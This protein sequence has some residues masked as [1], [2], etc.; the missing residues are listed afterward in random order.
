MKIITTTALALLILI[1]TAP[2]LMARDDSSENKSWLSSFFNPNDA[3]VFRDLVHKKKTLGV[4]YDVIEDSLRRSEQNLKEIGSIL[5]LKDDLLR[6]NSAKTR[7]STRISNYDEK[8]K[9]IQDSINDFKKK[10]QTTNT[11]QEVDKINNFIESLESELFYLS[12]DYE[13]DNERVNSINNDIVHINS[14]IQ[15]SKEES[16]K[17]AQLRNDL[18]TKEVEISNTDNRLSELLNRDSL[19][20]SFRLNISIAFTLLVGVVIVGFYR[21]A[22]TKDELAKT[23]FSGE[24]GIQFITLF[25]I[26]ISIILFGIMGSLQSEELSALLGALSGYILGR[27]SKNEE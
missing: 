23:I 3:V 13:D 9:R 5:I 18:K 20:N 4:E 15:Q 10:I 22:S 19:Q 25:L 27:T 6:A 12:E 2:E 14:R 21:I 26:I 1:F 7:Y 11:K 17:I 16:N 8:K 24:K